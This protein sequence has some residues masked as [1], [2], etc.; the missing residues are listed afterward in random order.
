MKLLLTHVLG[1]PGRLLQAAMR[2]PKPTTPSGNPMPPAVHVTLGRETLRDNGR[3]VI[4]G[5]I[6]GCNDEFGDLL[7][8]VALTTDDTLILVGDLVNK[9]PD[10]AGVVRRARDH[11]AYAVRGNH[12]DSGLSAYRAWQEG[13]DVKKKHAWVKNL[14]EEDAAWMSALPFTIAIPC[15][16]I[17]IVHAGLVPGVPLQ[18]Q[19]CTDMYKM[20]DVIPAAEAAAGECSDGR[21]WVGSERKSKAGKAWS[22][23]WPGPE[24]VFF[25]HDAKRKL[26]LREFA[27]GL[28]T[29]CCYGGQLTACVLPPLSSYS[30]SAAAPTEKPPQV[31][32]CAKGATLASL[33]GELVA[34]PCRMV[35]EEPT[36]AD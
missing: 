26:Q 30:G 9:G 2:A 25:G 15:Y 22:K 17:M 29:G 5:D 16:N 35:Y 33:K 31:D 3:L 4:V 1:F 12:D 14:S 34:V 32:T 36:G 24:H 23:K 11:N 28:D 20:R 13:E 27:T 6:H 8:K 21:S 19:S 7:E 18:D 10:S